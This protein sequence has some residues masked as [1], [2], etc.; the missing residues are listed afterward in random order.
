[1][2]E[3]IDVL[4]RFNSVNYYE[5][6]FPTTEEASNAINYCIKIKN[7]KCDNCKF[8]NFDRERYLPVHKCLWD[9]DAVNYGF[10]CSKHK[11]KE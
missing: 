3:V 1:M 5:E 6:N 10:S 11:Y 7:A 8:A 2:D 4:N 9:I